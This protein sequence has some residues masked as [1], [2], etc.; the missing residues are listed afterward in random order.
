M[1]GKAADAALA[2]IRKLCLALPEATERLSHGR[3][4]WFIRDKHNFCVFSDDHHGDGRLAIVCAA[5]PGA[6]RMLVD[7]APERYYVPPYVGVGGWIGLRLD[8]HPAPDEVAAVILDAWKTRAP[9]KILVAA[10]Y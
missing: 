9:K 3:P 1:P 8:R 5:P 6:Q 10:G 2:K 4:S 7:A